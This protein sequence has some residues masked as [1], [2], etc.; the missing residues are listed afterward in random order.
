MSHSKPL[1]VISGATSGIGRETALGL[2]SRGISL[3]L[4]VRSMDKGAALKQ[5]I[6]RQTGNEAIDLMHCELDHMASIRAFAGEFKKKYRRLDILVNNAGIWETRRKTSRDGIEMNFA[7]NHL[8]PFLMT[9]LLLDVIRGSAPA[10]IVNVSSMAHKQA[11]LRL[12]DLEGRKRWNR[13]ESYAQ[14]KLANILFTRRL[15]RDLE[16]SGVTVNCLHPGV[17]NTHLFDQM[18]ALI[19]WLSPWFMIGPEKGARTSIYLA[20][21]DEVAHISGEYFSRCKPARSSRQ[22]RSKE[23]ADKLWEASLAYCG[24]A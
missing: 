15:A 2:A 12:N 8:A 20:T 22:A 1:A 13:M 4:P 24:L 18:P 23:L 19:R 10:R 5:Q 17:V 9:H 16:S 14:S 3:V 6:I 21:S 11:R 7:V